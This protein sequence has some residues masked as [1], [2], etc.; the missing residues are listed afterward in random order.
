[1][2]SQFGSLCYK[3]ITNLD[4]KSSL[5]ITLKKHTHTHMQTHSSHAP[6]KK[7]LSLLFPSPPPTI[8]NNHLFHYTKPI[9]LQ[10]PPP[11]SHRKTCLPTLRVSAPSSLV[12]D[13]ETGE[14]EANFESKFS[15]RDHW[16]P[17]SLIEDLDP[18]IPTPFTLLN[19]DLVMWFDKVE[20]QWVVLKISLLVCWSVLW[21]FIIG[22][23]L[24][25]KVGS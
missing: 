17:A 25:L 11:S 14:F 5:Y 24:T 20:N 18:N 7:M 4:E 2:V 21:L 19:R 6:I 9:I 1:M 16:Y 13:L 10:P 23:H 12:N 8:T 3:H 22:N 15:W